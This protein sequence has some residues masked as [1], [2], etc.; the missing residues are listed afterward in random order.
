MAIGTV[1][2]AAA[3]TGAPLFGLSAFIANQLFDVPKLKDLIPKAKALKQEM[4]KRK[5][6]PVG[7]VFAH[8]R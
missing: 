5:K 3:A 1:E 4:D 6:S 7:L 8:K 2:I